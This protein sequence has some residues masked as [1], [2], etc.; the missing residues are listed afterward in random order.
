MRVRRKGGGYGGHIGHDTAGAPGDASPVPASLARKLATFE[1]GVPGPADT[2]ALAAQVEALASGRPGAFRARMEDARGALR[3]CA[4]PETSGVLSATRRQPRGLAGWITVMSYAAL[5]GGVPPAFLALASLGLI[6]AAAAYVAADGALA[7]MVFNF[8]APVLAALGVA[9][10][11]RCSG[12]GAWEM[13]MSSPVTPVQLT[14]ARLALVAGYNTAV[15]V[16]ASLAMWWGRPPDVVLQLVLTWFAPLVL[17][18]AFALLA[19]LRWGAPAAAGLTVALWGAQVAA[20]AYGLSYTMLRLPGDAG[21]AAAQLA[22]LVLAVPLVVAA[23]RTG[24]R[25]R[26]LCEGDGP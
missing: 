18:S 25:L 11:F 22:S 3:P 23:T 21:W 15:G 24:L 17:Y 8:I 7:V 14:L 1:V 6:G 16:A 12:A 26:D 9:Y 19:S 4:G 5:P 13:E 2:A 10:A 20:R